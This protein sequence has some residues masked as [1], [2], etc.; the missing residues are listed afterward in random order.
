[1]EQRED[2]SKRLTGAG[3]RR[4]YNIVAGKRG[5]DGLGLY[6]GRRYKAVLREVGLQD[7]GQRKFR[8]S[9]HSD[10]AKE[11]SEPTNETT[12]GVR[13]NFE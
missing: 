5:R 2:E 13:I 3:L 4:G 11:I 6:R 7:R 10:F 12:E 8:K 9:V 1:M